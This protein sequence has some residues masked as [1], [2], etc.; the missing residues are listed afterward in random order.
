MGML[1]QY[2]LGQ[3]LRQRYATLFENGSYSPETI[4]VESTVVKYFSKTC[5]FHSKLKFEFKF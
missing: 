2:G 1:Q 4:H 3:Y 5:N